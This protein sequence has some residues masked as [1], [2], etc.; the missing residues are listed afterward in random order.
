MANVSVA[1]TT[2]NISAQT[3]V[4]AGRDHTITGLHTFDRDPSAPFAVSANSAVVTNLD[5]DKLDGLDWSTA[6]TWASY[7]PTWAGSGG[8]PSVGN[9]TISGAYWTL[10]KSA[11]VF[12]S[13][14]WGSTTT[15][16]SA[17]AWTFSLPVTATRASGCG[18]LFDSSSGNLYPIT[19]YAV[20][21]TTVGIAFN[22]GTGNVTATNPMTWATG[23]IIQ[24]VLTVQVT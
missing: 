10:G 2:S 11:Q 20:T 21:G 8:S 14:T 5:A 9:G 22:N 17:T 15:A 3:I 16:N 4:L 19:Y 23:D 1:N 18:M 6:F 12:F 13:L 7:T 24:G